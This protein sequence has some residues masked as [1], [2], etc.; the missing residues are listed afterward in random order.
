MANRRER[1]NAKRQHDQHQGFVTGVEEPGSPDEPGVEVWMTLEEAADATG[2]SQAILQYWDVTGKVAT[3]VTPTANG[4]RKELLLSDV[5][6]GLRAAIER[7]ERIEEVGREIER[8]RTEREAFVE[9]L[10]SIR[11]EREHRIKELEQLQT[12][13]EEL[14]AALEQGR[15][16]EENL[17]RELERSR[18]E[19]A[20]VLKQAE[21]ADAIAIEFERG[22]AEVRR[23]VNLFIGPE[24]PDE[25]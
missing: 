14:V 24:E 4:G 10:D 3:R 16:A 19:R 22:L 9:Q 15:A 2:L 21:E 20:E 12:E 7:Q 18:E 23:V 17:V 11:A 25:T 6:E 5:M 1:K 8:A 13:R